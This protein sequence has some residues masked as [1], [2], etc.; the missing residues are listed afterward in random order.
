MLKA[1]GRR[2]RSGVDRIVTAPARSSVH[3]VAGLE[4]TIF[5]VD[6]VREFTDRAFS[7][8]PR[9][10]GQ[11]IAISVAALRAIRVLETS[12]RIGIIFRKV[13]CDFVR[14]F[15]PIIGG[16]GTD[17][18]GSQ[19]GPFIQTFPLRRSAEAFALAVEF[20]RA[21]LATDRSD[22]VVCIISEAISTGSTKVSTLS[23][24]L[25]RRQG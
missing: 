8:C 15:T 25:C 18:F 22:T 21:E 6:E 24:G 23:G 5:I 7:A 4:Q 9:S 14:I 17:V 13:G 11:W 3:D 12:D 20:L 2:E 10:I 1:A 16:V 19:T